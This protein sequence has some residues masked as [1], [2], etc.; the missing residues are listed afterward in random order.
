VHELPGMLRRHRAAL[1]RRDALRGIPR[2]RGLLQKTVIGEQHAL[3][4]LGQ[5]HKA[6]AAAL[7]RAA[8]KTCRRKVAEHVNAAHTLGIEVV[9][10]HNAVSEE[11]IVY[12]NTFRLRNKI[13]QQLVPPLKAASKSQLTHSYQPACL[14]V[15]CWEGKH[16]AVVK[17]SGKRG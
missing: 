15:L 6:C 1:T 16:V 9:L 14:P 17:P 13:G 12:G 7:A 8:Y 2:G 5:R 4:K 10:K 3:V 11:K